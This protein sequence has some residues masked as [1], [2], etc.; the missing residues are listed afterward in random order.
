[1]YKSKSVGV[2]CA[3]LFVGVLLSCATYFGIT[4]VMRRG[5]Q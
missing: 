5:G 1:M 3:T 2:V 4:A